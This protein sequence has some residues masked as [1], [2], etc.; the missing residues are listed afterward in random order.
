[1]NNI[2]SGIVFGLLVLICIVFKSTIK[3]IL[4]ALFV[5]FI[6]V[7]AV[8]NLILFI[9]ELPEMWKDSF[10]KSFFKDNVVEL[11]VFAV[12]ALPY[13]LIIFTM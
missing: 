11:S 13:I 10:K 3:D 5:I 4:L 12:C 2:V 6:I 1:M 7:C 9:K 8:N